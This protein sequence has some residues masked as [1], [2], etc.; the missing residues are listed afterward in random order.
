MELNGHLRF[1]SDHDSIRGASVIPSGMLVP[2]PGYVTADARIAYRLT[3]RLTLAVS[4]DNLLTSPQRQT[5][6]AAVERQVMVTR[7]ASL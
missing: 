7:S 5:S 1:S 4:G 3:D 2:I 6:S